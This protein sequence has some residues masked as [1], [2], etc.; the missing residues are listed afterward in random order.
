V[1]AEA[2]GA[3]VHQLGGLDEVGAVFGVGGRH[4]EDLGGMA[5]D[6]QLGA[7]VSAVSSPTPR[8]RHRLISADLVTARN[9]P[10]AVLRCL[11][12]A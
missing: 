3:C 2:F 1:L 12:A 11:T 7:R 4:D 9:A 5:H 8:A 10:V 6:S